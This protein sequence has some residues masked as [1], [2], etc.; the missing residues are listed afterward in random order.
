MINKKR[1]APISR[2][3]LKNGQGKS[4]GASWGL[5]ILQMIFLLLIP[6]K[7]QTLLLVSGPSQQREINYGLTPQRPYVLIY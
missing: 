7:R 3:S 1:T 4:Y 2:V 6:C 5:N